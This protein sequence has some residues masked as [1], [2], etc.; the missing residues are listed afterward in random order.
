M[1]AIARETASGAD[2]IQQIILPDSP[3]PEADVIVSVGHV[4]NYLDDEVAIQKSLIAIAGA[5]SPGGIL[6]ID[7]QDLQWGSAYRNA[8]NQARVADDWALISEFA[9]PEPNRFIRRHISF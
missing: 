3:L 8:S 5:L 7:M 1:L 4:L 9:V 6:A 2:D